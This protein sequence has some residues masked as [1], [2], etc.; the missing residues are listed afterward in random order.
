VIVLGWHT[1]LATAVLV[2]AAIALALWILGRI[3]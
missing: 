3:R 2:L 1:T